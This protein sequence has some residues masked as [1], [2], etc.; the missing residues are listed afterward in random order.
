MFPIPLGFDKKGKRVR[1]I[2][3]QAEH[4]QMLVEIKQHFTGI[5]L[6]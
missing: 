1:T 5:W 6:V 4:A 3:D 2:P